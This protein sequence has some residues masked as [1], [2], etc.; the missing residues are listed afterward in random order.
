[1]ARLRKQFRKAKQSRPPRGVSTPHRVHRSLQE[2]ET[3]FRAVWDNAADLIFVVKS[4]E[5]TIEQA[6]P[7]FQSIGFSPAQLVGQDAMG[8]IHPEDRGSLHDA[9]DEMLKQG[10]DGHVIRLRCLDARGAAHHVEVHGCAVRNRKHQVE[11]FVVVAR[12]VDDCYAAEAKLRERERELQLLLDSTAEGIYG[13]D[14]EGKCTFCNKACLRLLGYADFAQL[15]GKQIREQIC[16]EFAHPI[17]PSDACSAL[18]DVTRPDAV[19]AENGAFRRADGTLLPVEFWSYPMCS[20]GRVIGRVVAFVNIAE[21]KAAEALL[22]E[23]HREA[24]LFIDAVPS[25][26]I[27]L[28]AKGCIRRWNT[29]ASRTFGL[30]LAEVSGKPLSS[31]GIKWLSPLSHFPAALLDQS[32]AP[33]KWDAIAFESKGA[34]RLLGLKATWITLPQS[35]H[36][37]LLVVGADI[38]DRKRAQDELGWKTALLEAQVRASI[39]GILVVDEHGKVVLRN[40][41]LAD[42][43]GVPDSLRGTDEDNVLLQYVQHQVENPDEFLEKVKYLYLHKHE[44]S[45][46]EIHLKNGTVLDRYSS[47]VF[48]KDSEYYGR[49]WTFRDITQ[50]KQNEASLRQLSVAVEQSPVSVVITDLK[51]NI[52]YVNRRFSECTGYS[53]EEAIGQNPRIL[54]SDYTSPQEYK[55]LWDTINRGQEWRGELRN[56]KKNGDLYWESVVISPIRNSSGQTSHFLAVKED[57]TEKKITE[58]HS[59]Q[60]QKLEAIGQLA[61]GIAHEINTPIQFVG[62]NARFV[63]ESWNALDPA[64]ALLQ[65]TDDAGSASALLARVRQIL[66]DCDAAYLQTE[67]PRALDQSLEG[68]ARVAK[69]VRAMKEFS[70]PGSDEKQLADI[71]KAVLTTLTVA[72][73]EWKYVAEVETVLAPDM[74]LVPCHLGE[75]NQ[76]FLNLLINSAHAIAEVVG[77]ASKG[78][79]KITIRTTQDKDCTIISVADTG[80]GIPR[81]IQSKV[82]DPFF[83][84]KGVGRGTGQGLSLAHNSI[85]KKHK[86]RIWF[87]TETGKGTTFF[88]QLPRAPGMS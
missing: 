42:L 2:A 59:R 51:G 65:K 76:V 4:P 48:G 7:A 80:R 27:G 23:A 16:P 17:G 26:L 22:R 56:K 62:D 54:K 34:R 70:H 15:L 10:R 9:I 39:D 1:M 60:A 3:L 31:C 5:M 40:E 67:V 75:L 41:R 43:F 35:G 6:N 24:E 30:S 61:A 37:E 72:R 33:K 85:V 81:E 20:D 73:N 38:T 19:H 25:I 46:D 64:F 74:E 36:G 87:E 88:I 21:R 14:T 78:K 55:Q 18:G 32:K 29:A 84:T 28:D 49:I 52:T 69:I 13:I 45:R 66:N 79:G 53:A 47:A 44:T 82:F 8:F 57:I 71:N 77:D 63:K 50:R 12:S 68:I 11:R 86:G 83:T 58:A